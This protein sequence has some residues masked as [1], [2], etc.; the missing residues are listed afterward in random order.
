MV[1]IGIFTFSKL[2]RQIY[3][4]RTLGEA[5]EGGDKNWQSLVNIEQS[6]QMRRVHRTHLHECGGL[7][8]QRGEK[9][10]VYLLERGAIERVHGEHTRFPNQEEFKTRDK[11]TGFI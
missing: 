2:I 11:P 10:K 4:P 6:L 3:T 9:E 5:R 1:K 8:C 7:V